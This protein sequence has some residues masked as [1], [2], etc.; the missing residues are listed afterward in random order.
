MA[1]KRI[2]TAAV[3]AGDLITVRHTAYPV[4]VKYVPWVQGRRDR[5]R[6]VMEDGTM[7]W[8]AFGGTVL[9]HN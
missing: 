4:R 9:K 1:T 6:V 7:V 3:K 8:H 5:W 2:S